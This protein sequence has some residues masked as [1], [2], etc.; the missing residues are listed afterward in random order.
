MVKW[1][2]IPEMMAKSGLTVDAD[3]LQ[4]MIDIRLLLAHTPGRSANRLVC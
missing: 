4:V 1:A 2:L 3:S